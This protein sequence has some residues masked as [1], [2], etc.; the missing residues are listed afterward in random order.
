MCGHDCGGGVCVDSVCQV[1]QPI[2]PNGYV[3]AVA[4]NGEYIFYA[5]YTEVS[6][7]LPK[8]AIYR[9]GLGPGTEAPVK[10]TTDFNGKVRHIAATCD[11]VYW[12]VTRETVN[13]TSST[14]HIARVSITTMVATPSVVASPADDVVAMA[15]EGDLVVWASNA[16]ATG[17][18]GIKAVRGAGQVE[19][20]AA[21]APLS[22]LFADVAIRDGYVYWSTVDTMR[23]G[24]IFRAPIPTSGGSWGTP[25]DVRMMAGLPESIAVDRNTVYWVDYFSSGPPVIRKAPADD[26]SAGDITIGSLSPTPLGD[27]PSAWLAVDDRNVYAVD[28]NSGTGSVVRFGLEMNSPKDVIASSMNSM[29]ALNVHAITLD[30]RRVYIAAPSAAGSHVSWVAK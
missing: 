6:G 22:G 13:M 9:I 26:P 7:V 29:V 4:T 23:M 19:L 1:V 16:V 28:T 20:V 30:L 27:V 2:A 18:K 17:V 5:S 11:N 3:Y 10:L 8:S 24:R 14:P 21:T 12:A 25:I 15:A